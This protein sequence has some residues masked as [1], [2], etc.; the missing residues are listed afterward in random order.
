M[1]WF[2]AR[3]PVKI[4]L[5]KALYFFIVSYVSYVTIELFGF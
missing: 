5:L 2:F 4:P 1:C 3:D